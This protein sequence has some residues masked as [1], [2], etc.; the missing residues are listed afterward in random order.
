[1]HTPLRAS[2]AAKIAVSYL[3][4]SVAWILLSDRLARWA[5]PDADSL[6]WVQSTKGLGFVIGSSAVIYL[7]LLYTS[8]S[9]R[10]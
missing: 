7:C 10:D 9:P 8:P 2:A 5:L 1:M 3:V 6:T 4:I